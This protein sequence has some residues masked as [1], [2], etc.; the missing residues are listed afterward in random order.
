M[1]TGGLRIRRRSRVV[2][3][4]DEGIGPLSVAKQDSRADATAKE[5][6]CGCGDAGCKN[7]RTLLACV[8]CTETR[9]PRFMDANTFGRVVSLH[10]LTS[11]YYRGLCARIRA[12]LRSSSHR[13]GS[14]P[15]LG[16]TRSPTQLLGLITVSL[17]V[18]CT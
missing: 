11:F 12:T 13:D 10:L 2:G 8:R 6:N 5:E 9:A 16:C 14:M 15:K 18:G 3:A 1:A 4:L 17:L 7:L